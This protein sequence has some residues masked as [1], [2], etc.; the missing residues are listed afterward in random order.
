MKLTD[1]FTSREELLKALEA[2]IK[3]EEGEFVLDYQIDGDSE[4]LKRQ[5]EQLTKQLSDAGAENKKYRLTGNDWKKKFETLEAEHE[6]VKATLEELQ[7]TN[8]TNLQEQLRAFATEKGELASQLKKLAKSNEELQ[9]KVTQYETRDTESRIKED[10][11]REAKNAGVRDD[12]Q[13][14]IKRLY[15]EFHYN[16]AGL[17][18]TQDGK[19]ASEFLSEEIQNAP[20]I[21][22]PASQ[23]GG[24]AAG[25]APTKSETLDQKVSEALKS[26][27]VANMIQMASELGS[28]EE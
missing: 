8:P 9:G 15:R 12:A 23:G 6:T 3:E 26:G 24:S 27:N 19:T 5:V 2:M 4:E 21:F 16:D 10:L 25:R 1:R 22:L 20:A 11:W 7:K 18:E 17:L 13:S 14:V 28:T